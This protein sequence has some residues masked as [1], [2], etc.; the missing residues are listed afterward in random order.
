MI[1]AP[2]YNMTKVKKNEKYLYVYIYMHTHKILLI[3]TKNMYLLASTLIAT[4]FSAAFDT[5]SSSQLVKSCAD[6]SSSPEDRVI[7]CDKQLAIQMNF[8]LKFLS[9]YC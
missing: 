8:N 9:S 2:G 3:N 5:F 1:I 6:C 4:Q 7:K